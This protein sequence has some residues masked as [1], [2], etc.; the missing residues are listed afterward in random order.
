MTFALPGVLETKTK[1]QLSCGVSLDR[2]ETTAVLGYQN[3][4]VSKREKTTKREAHQPPLAIVGSRLPV[5]PTPSLLVRMTTAI[6]PLV[7]SRALI[8]YTPPRRPT[9][10][11]IVERFRVVSH[12]SWHSGLVIHALSRRTSLVRKRVVIIAL[13]AVAQVSGFSTVLAIC[14]VRLDDVVSV[15]L[16]VVPLAVVDV[17]PGARGVTAAEAACG[18][19]SLRVVALA[20]VGRGGGCAVVAEA[21]IARRAGL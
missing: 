9:E 21:S 19:L 18:T 7:H 15:S 14:I 16:H 2:E 13:P 11:R 1:E 12:P 20:S 10:I 17:R 8:I 5:T 4:N 6:V 3:M